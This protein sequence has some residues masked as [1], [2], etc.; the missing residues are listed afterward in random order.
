[1]VAR[2]RRVTSSTASLGIAVAVAA[3]VL[4]AKILDQIAG[5]WD[6]QFVSLALVADVHAALV[7]DCAFPFL[8]PKISFG[9]AAQA[10]ANS[11]PAAGTG[12]FAATRQSTVRE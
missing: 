7:A 11:A 8:V 12:S 9:A 5:V 10:A 3:L 2:R 1:M 6:I 4:T